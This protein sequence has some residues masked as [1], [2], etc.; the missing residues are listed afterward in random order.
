MVTAFAFAEHNGDSPNGPTIISS[1]WAV[2]VRNEED[3]IDNWLAMEDIASGRFA[4]DDYDFA[5]PCALL[6]THQAQPGG[7]HQ[8]SW[9]VYSCWPGGYTEMGDGQNHARVRM[10]RFEAEREYAKGKDNPRNIAPGVITS[11]S[12][13][14]PTRS[15]TRLTSSNR[16]AMTSS[17]TFTAVTSV[18]PA[19]PRHPEV[20]L[21]PYLP[22][23]ITDYSRMPS[24]L[25][26]PA[27]KRSPSSARPAKKSGPTSTPASKSSSTGVA[28]GKTT[29]TARAGSASAKAGPKPTTASRTSRASSKKSS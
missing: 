1:A 7:Y 24:S 5:K 29:K 3:Y 19:V 10:E 25:V 4:A 6:D 22:A 8:D 27:R 9:E 18:T 16:P 28:A 11:P 17:K 20:V 2:Q 12:A 13:D 14:T 15:T 23:P 26:A 21:L